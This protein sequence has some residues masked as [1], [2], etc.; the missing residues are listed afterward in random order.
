[1]ATSMNSDRAAA[2]QEARSC[3]VEGYA[4]DRFADVRRIFEENIRDGVDVGASLSVAVAGELVVDLWGGWS[5]AGRTRP[6]QQDTLV[7]VYSVSKTMAAMTILL[8]A[9]KAVLDP[10]A[11]VAFYWPEFAQSG[12]K[13]VRLRHL[14]AHSAGL[15]GWK[16]PMATTDLFDW[17]KATTLLARQQ[18]Y[19][20]PGS[21]PGYHGITQG[22]LL[23]EVVRRATGEMLGDIFQREIAEPLGADFHLGLDPV[24]HARVAPMIAERTHDGPPRGT[25]TELMINAVTNPLLYPFMTEATGTAEW[26]AAHIYAANG[27]GNARSIAKAHA[28]L[29]NGG[30]VGGRR[31]LSEAWCRR[32]LKLQIEGLDLVLGMPARF[33]LGFGLP[34]DWLEAPHS[35]CIF[36]PGS[37]GAMSLVDL[38]AR[39]SFGYAMN[40][41]G[42]SGTLVDP[43]PMKLL[44]AVWAAL[45]DF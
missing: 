33:G 14:L 10:D 42:G 8:L 18:P 17:E 2:S 28:L 34:G 23:G 11:T 29:A 37:G 6:W 38:R 30:E 36:W 20:E 13:E 39:M 5:D 15:S 1:M 41:R 26:T 4:H 12:K 35:D 43:R 9:D 32:A 16:E 31:L 25:P 24:H 40:Q 22:F 21:A 3:L 7:N 45:S 44:R 19:W 27:Q